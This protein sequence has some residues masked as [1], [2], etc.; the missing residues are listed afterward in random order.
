ME[1]G[2]DGCGGSCGTCPGGEEC[3]G[4]ACVCKVQD[5]LACS[6][7]ALYWYDSCDVQGS[8][9]SNC[10][11]GNPCTD[12]GCTG[13][14]CTHVNAEDGTPCGDG[15]TCQDG[16]CQYECGDGVCASTPPGTEDCC[17]CPEDCGTCCGNWVC[18]CGET[19]GTCPGD[20]D[21]GCGEECVD[22][23]CAFTACAG[24][25]CGEDGCGGSCGTCTG[26]EVCEAGACICQVEYAQACFEGM[27]YWYDSCGGQGSLVSDCDDGSS[28]TTDG[29]S[30]DQCVHVNVEDG[31]PCGGEK[32]CWNGVCEYHC[33]DG[34]CSSIPPGTETCT[35]CPADCGDCPPMCDPAC[36][37]D[38]EE[39]VQSTTGDW[40]CAAKMVS[41]PAGNFWMGCNNCPDTMPWAVDVDC[42]SD[43]HPYHEVYLDGY[44]IDKT[45]VTAAQYL[46][47]A[48][49]NICTPAGTGGDATYDAPGKEDNP[50]NQVT[51]FQAVTY[52]LWAGKG[53]CTEAQWEK[54]ARGGCEENGGPSICKTQ[55]RKYPWGNTPPT[56]NLAYMSGCPGNT[57]PVCS[58]SPA[59]DSPYEL[60]DMAGNVNEY[61]IDYYQND[62]YCD[63]DAA[64]GDGGCAECGPWPGSPDAWEN[65]LCMEYNTAVVTR[66]GG[67]L[68]LFNLLR[69]SSRHF[70]V[71]STV[72]GGLGF[73]CCRS[74]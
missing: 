43:E 22:G 25:E 27:L 64:S 72:S 55:N 24:K 59:A 74:D 32:S 30:G 73:R 68:H 65:P 48:T 42:E 38:L 57:G 4:G 15:I 7:G 2:D 12:D 51:W 70:A 40:T 28:C 5:H 62:Y 49:T 36:D 44:E 58:L 53:L 9:M 50:I 37:P 21:C 69:V 45:E 19:C 11:D 16:V 60:C 54:G 39:C 46:A 17:T 47:C 1:C 66:G 67:F 3:Q 41:I 20:C 63:G 6:D 33:G 26:G 29:C 14:E 31:T 52:C 71:P 18:D 23:D 10:D 34:V 56:C 8:L 13:S 61:V 35:T